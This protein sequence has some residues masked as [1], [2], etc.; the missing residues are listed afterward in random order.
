MSVFITFLRSNRFIKI[1]SFFFFFFLIFNLILFLRFKNVFFSSK[2]SK[3]VENQA[4]GCFEKECLK[5]DSEKK[6]PPA[7]KEMVSLDEE[8]NSAH[9]RGY[10]VGWQKDGEVLR[11]NVASSLEDEKR[12]TI[13]LPITSF[14][15]WHYFGKSYS[16]SWRVNGEPYDFF[17]KNVEERESLFEIGD[18][19]EVIC[20]LKLSDLDAG[21]WVPKLIIV[22]SR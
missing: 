19:I 6:L 15:Q 8:S 1:V 12:Y 21:L 3:I 10:F 14:N 11:M 17:S 9:I 20:D 13:F 22:E 4:D 5:E 16:L 2:S 18:E 7:P